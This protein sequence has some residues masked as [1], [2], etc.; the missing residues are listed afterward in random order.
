MTPIKLPV[1]VNLCLRRPIHY[2]VGL[3][4][5]LTTLLIVNKQD[6]ISGLHDIG[7]SFLSVLY[8]PA[9][10]P[11][12]ILRDLVKTIEIQC[13]GH[14]TKSIHKKFDDSQLLSYFDVFP[15]L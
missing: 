11:F 2:V 12:P 14:G 4:H 5:H 6:N 10:N 7:Y 8:F 13:L 3:L 15:L 1:L 9:S